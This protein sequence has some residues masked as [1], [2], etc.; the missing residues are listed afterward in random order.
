MINAPQIVQTEAQDTAV[1]RF[2]IPRE[3]MQVVMGPAIDE[4]MVA[5]AAQGLAPAG[6]VFA[7]HFRMD[8]DVFD[9]E[10]GVGVERP[11]AASGCVMPGQLPAETVAR[12]VYHG[13]YEGLPEAW[14]EFMAWIQT[15]GY[16]PAPNL[17]ERCLTNPEAEPD[18][19]TWR[20]ELNR[21]ERR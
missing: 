1:I 15:G 12:T 16:E 17:W 18:P 13:P 5:I 20:T 3:E 2:N 10:I 21:P 19:A 11:V 6:P 8:P 9:F 7:H 14:G 4:V